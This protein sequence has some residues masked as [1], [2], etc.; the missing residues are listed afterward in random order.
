MTLEDL[1]I[2]QN[3]EAFLAFRKRR[4]HGLQTGL[5]ALDKVL[6]GMS[7]VTLVQ[8]AP[9]TNKSTL[10]MQIALHNAQQGTPVLIVDREN[11]RER[12]RTRLVCC[13]AR[14][15][16][17]DVLTAPEEELGEWVGPLTEL[18]IYHSTAPTKPEGVRQLVSAILDK[19][20]RPM[21][22]VIDSLQ[23]M[24][25]LAD[26]ERMSIQQWLNELDQMKLDFEG[27]LT[28]LVT[29][30]KS[31]GSDNYDKASMAAAKG[32][33]AIE[34]KSEIVIDVR[35]SKEGGLVLEV[36]KNRDGVA[37]VAVDLERVLADH[38]NSASFCF[39]LEAA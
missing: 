21:L 17:V 8:G 28:V 22:L 2:N 15:S 5:P 33:G 12:F 9:G 6:L 32:A 39:R 30:E 11:G 27:K 25:A 3:W 7:G 26:N 18:P 31:R 38:S 23:A 29:S 1:S 34:Y 35:Q 13:S 19:F 4:L 10:V 36:V 20:N 14:K 16:S 37:N 24:P